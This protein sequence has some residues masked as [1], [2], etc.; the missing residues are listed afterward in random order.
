MSVRFFNP[1]PSGEYSNLSLAAAFYNKTFSGKTYL[2]VTNSYLPT[3][4]DDKVEILAVC[5]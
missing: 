2:P 1:L 4:P 3:F 5:V